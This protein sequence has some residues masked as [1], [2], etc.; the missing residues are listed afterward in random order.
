M[1]IKEVLSGLVLC[2]ALTAGLGGAAAGDW[3]PDAAAGAQAYGRAN[4][5][6]MPQPDGTVIC[7]AEEFQVES[8]GW[9]AKNWTTNY[10]A[11]TFGNSFLSRKAYLG[12]PEQCDES[13][14][15]REVQVPKAGRYLALVRYEAQPLF[16]TQFRLVIEQ[17]GKVVLD[18][19]YAAQPAGGVSGEGYDVHM[20]LQRGEG[21]LWEGQDVYVDLQPGRIKLTLIAGR[22][23]FDPEAQTRREGLAARR[24]VDCIMLT[25]DEAQIKDRMEREMY[26]LSGMLTQAGDLYLKLHNL[27]DGSK[28]TLNVPPGVEHSPYWVH[29]RNWKPRTLAADPGQSTDWVEVGSLLDS[30]N[31]GQWRLTAQPVEDSGALHYKLEFGVK[32]ADGT[33]ESIRM[34]ESGS[35]GIELA[36]DANTR[37]TKRIRP[38]NDV[39]YDLV[40]YLKKH[41]VRGRR[42]TRSLVVCVTFPPKP[43]DPKYMAARAEFIR[44]IGISVVAHGEPEPVVESAIPTGYI[45][46]RGS[47]PEQLEKY[48]SELQAQ[49][50]ADQIAIVSL[51][52]ELGLQ[53]PPA[54]DNAGFRKW[55]QGK[56]LEPSDVDP[57]AGASWDKV[58][59]SPGDET[60][61]VNPSLFY[62]SHLYR[63]DYGIQA[64]KALT[65]VLRRCLPNA[66]IGYNYPEEDRGNEDVGETHMWVRM[67]RE[68]GMTMPWGA[69]FV[70][71]RAEGSQQMSFIRVDLFRAGL[72]GKPDGKIHSYIMP[73]WPGNTPTSWRRQFYGDIAHGTKVVNLFGFMPVQAAY[74]ENYV[75]SPEMYQGVR[76]SLYETGLFEDIM[77]DGVI[78][79]GLAAFWFSD[80]GDIWRDR[81]KPFVPDRRTLYV[82]ILH[83]QLPLD[84]VIEEDALAGDLSQYKVLYLTDSHVSR[85]ASQA[86]ADWVAR[87]GRLF[88]TA[89]AGMFDE[90]NRP[91]E[92]LRELLGVEETGSVGP[93]KAINNCKEALPFEKPLET[94]TWQGPTGPGTMLVIGALSRIEARGAEVQGTFSDG[95]PAV[96]MKRT[97][98][99]SATYCAFLPGLSYFKPAMELRPKER[100][101]SRDDSMGHY[102]PTKFSRAAGELIGSPATDVERPVLCSA[103]RVDTRIIRAKEGVL[104]PLVNWSGAPIK[105]L[106]VTVS[107]EVPTADATL[108]S[109]KPV[110]AETGD[111]KCVFTFDL[112]VADAL[113]LR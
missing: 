73:H 47:T 64:Q 40:D 45:D 67:F 104:I 46:L 70:Y 34:F 13:V 93:L 55:L 83:Q 24:N 37:Y 43:D 1:R 38:I 69:D 101:T 105:G 56:G 4:P 66:G 99:G 31:D 15:T 3:E 90:F 95:S 19:L 75:N 82:A 68:D 42:P 98:E 2:I 61:S 79:P 49:G 44:M 100:G 88:A 78:D 41:P 39:L 96:T 108:A 9:E 77:Q 60:A 20:D 28:M 84:F 33:V 10:Y 76:T 113:I 71:G 65:D 59:Y 6:V 12:A 48:C 26:K 91:N 35:E 111:G 5:V 32:S 57:A 7:E 53:V 58:L 110:R 86:I 18:R 51:G 8:P 80:T 94:V 36:Y 16:E 74:T 87:G 85:A 109:G 112:D 72:K 25:T 23:V 102:V 52:D 63:H 106:T 92:I 97:G 14:A 62:Y 81:S 54:D 103:P 11:K 21:I 29:I 22:Q 17:G 50:R 89:G 27:P 107:A 30:L